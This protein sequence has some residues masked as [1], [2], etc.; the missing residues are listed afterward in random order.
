VGKKSGVKVVIRMGGTSVGS[1]EM[2]DMTNL[3]WD[4]KRERF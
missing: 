1:A 3:K 4:C 2:W